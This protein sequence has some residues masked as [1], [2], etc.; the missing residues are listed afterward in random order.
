LRT[1]SVMLG[2]MHQMLRDILREE[3]LGGRPG[4]AVVSD[5]QSDDELLA[6]VVDYTPDIVV[7]ESM[8]GALGYAGALVLRGQPTTSVL[9]LSA[10][11]RSAVIYQLRASGAVMREVSPADLREA[12]RDAVVTQA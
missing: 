4:F 10:D 8:Q 1:I 5:A 6:A 9:A 3:V 11:T 12:I 7:V 2:T